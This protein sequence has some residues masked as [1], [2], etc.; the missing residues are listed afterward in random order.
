MLLVLQITNLMSR[1]KSYSQQVLDETH[2]RWIDDP[3]SRN[4][5]CD[6]PLE[7]FDRSDSV[8]ENTHERIVQETKN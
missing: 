1:Y 2:G 6:E 4:E 8:N 5:E 7:W 3:T